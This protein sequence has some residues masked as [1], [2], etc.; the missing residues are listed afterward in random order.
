MENMPC[1]KTLGWPAAWAATSSWC[2]GLKSPEAPAYL[3]RSVLRQLVRHGR[4]LVP[5]AHVLEEQ[6]LLTHRLA[7]PRSLSL[8]HSATRPRDA[9]RAPTTCS[10]TRCPSPP[11]V[12][13]WIRLKRAVTTGSPVVSSDQLVSLDDEGHRRPLD[14]FW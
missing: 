13:R 10:A 4:G 7:S 11:S 8:S 14:S 3:T 12:P 9:A 1:P 6:L 5:H 2:I